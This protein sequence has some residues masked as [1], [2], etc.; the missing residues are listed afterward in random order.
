MSS[1]LLMTIGVA[2]LLLAALAIAVLRVLHRQASP[3]APELAESKARLEQLAAQLAGGQISPEAFEEERLQ[4]ARRLLDARGAVLERAVPRA[5]A[6]RRPV[7]AF[8]SA[9]IVVVCMVVLYFGF[10]PTR[11]GSGQAGADPVASSPGTAGAD[12]ALRLTAQQLSAMADGARAQTQKDPKDAHAWAMLAHSLDMLGEFAE[13]TKAYARLAEL[14]PKDA[15]VLADY[16]DALAVAQ[17]RTLKGEPRALIDKALALDA[18]NLK[19]LTLAGT[20]AFERKSYAQAA[21]YW[22]RARA[23][24][25][26][27][28]VTR[29]IDASLD[30]ARTLA[31]EPVSAHGHATDGALLAAASVSGRVSIA[32]EVAASASPDDVV[33]IFARPVQGSRMPVALMRKHVR[34]LPLDFSLDDSMAMVAEQR[35][36]KQ[37]QVVVG[38]RVSKRG[39]A[40]PQA[41]DLQGFTGPVR[42]G[43]GGLH[44]DIGEVVK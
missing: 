38:A 25:I 28:S 32:P 44:L 9:G 39:D 20:E 17:G 5:R 10:R 4:A 37:S 7:V 16:A 3:P 18:R 42:V 6:V 36:S 13:S 11:P 1:D 21:R 41:G 24:S 26:D 15:E 35:L 33:F 23:V 8:A 43:A 30:E 2:V 34:D 19:A 12:S 29:Q 27:P 31:G 22:E 40:L 14:L